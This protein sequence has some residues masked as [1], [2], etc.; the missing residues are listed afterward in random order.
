MKQ[1]ISHKV[2]EKREDDFMCS[3]YMPRCKNVFVITQTSIHLQTYIERGL[4][5]TL[6]KRVLMTPSIYK[7]NRNGQAT[8]PYSL[9]LAV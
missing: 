1:V 6:N 5:E 3:S 8:S 2:Y 4:A 7:A 9:G